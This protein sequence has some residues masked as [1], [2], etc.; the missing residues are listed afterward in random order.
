MAT[1]KKL[2][3]KTA[4]KKTAAKASKKATKTAS[5]KV[6]S[7]KKAVVKKVAAKKAARKVTSRAKATSTKRV[8]AKAKASTK[9]VATKATTKRTATKK[10]VRVRRKIALATATSVEG[11]L[12]QVYKVLAQRDAGLQSIF[13]RGLLRGTFSQEHF[14][15]APAGLPF[16]AFGSRQNAQ[17][18]VDRN[19][20]NRKEDWSPWIIVT[21]QGVIGQHA[22]RRVKKI[23]DFNPTTMKQLAADTEEILRQGN[24]R[25][26]KKRRF[27]GNV[28]NNPNK[29][30]AIGTIFVQ[31][32]KITQP[33]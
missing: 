4:S 15:I 28:P 33:S 5:K 11:R 31:N 32:F 3:K 22:P 19:N 30:W 17:R 26:T 14:V 25:Y 23:H 29:R 18:Y 2:A 27:S 10:A 20:R 9:R 12:T 8:V 16:T 13:A 6:A 1:R 24:L 21:G 7:K